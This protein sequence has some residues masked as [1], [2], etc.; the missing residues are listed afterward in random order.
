MGDLIT[1]LKSFISIQ[2]VDKVGRTN[3]FSNGLILNPKMNKCGEGMG[4]Y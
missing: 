4:E 1:A 2:K 3:P